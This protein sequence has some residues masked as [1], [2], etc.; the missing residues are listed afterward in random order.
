MTR[1]SQIGVGGLAVETPKALRRGEGAPQLQ[2]MEKLVSMNCGEEKKSAGEG[3]WSVERDTVSR[4]TIVFYAIAI[5][6][7]IGCE[8][9]KARTKRVGGRVDTTGVEQEEGTLSLRVSFPVSS[10]S[11]AHCVCVCVSM[12]LQ[13]Y[14]RGYVWYIHRLTFIQCQPQTC[15]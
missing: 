14:E 15:H 8:N 1:C 4:V 5:D 3:V 7:V 9:V 6:K 13:G 12:Y 10:R 11:Q 2:G